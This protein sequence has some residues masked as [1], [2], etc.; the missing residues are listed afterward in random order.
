MDVIDALIKNQREH[1]QSN[2]DLRPGLLM[3]GWDPPNATLIAQLNEEHIPCIYV[4]PTTTDSYN[5][6]AQLANFTAKLSR[7][8]EYRLDLAIRHVSKHVNFDL[9]D[10]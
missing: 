4:P 3:T 8:D 7:A 10:I 9:I 2:Q 5:L 1:R 6:M